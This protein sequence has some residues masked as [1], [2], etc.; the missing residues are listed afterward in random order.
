MIPHL[1]YRSFA[2]MN[3]VILHNLHKFPHNIDLIVGIPRSG[4][5]PAYLLALYLNK[6]VSD[7]DSFIEGRIQRGGDRKSIDKNTEIKKVLFLDDSFGLGAATNRLKKQLLIA[8]ILEKYE[9]FYAAIYTTKAGKSILD[10]YC[11]EVSTPR[12]FQWNIFHLGILESACCDIDGVL[13]PDPPIDDDGPE[14]INYITNAPSLYIPTV[15]IDT[16]VSCRLEKYRNIT[17]EWLHR[18]GVKYK[19]LIMLDLPDKA[20][21][22][23]WGKHGKYKAEVYKAENYNLFIE[24]SLQEALIIKKETGK[25]VFCVET[26]DMLNSTSMTEKGR[27][28]WEDVK[29]KPWHVLTFLPSIIMPQTYKKIKKIFKK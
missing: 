5:L 26:F 10:Y 8:G 11:E 3:S 13:C 12:A 29:R 21:R 7:V 20:T 24:S 27:Y 25:P 2:D 6:P 14:Y 22:V 4:M 1:E 23:A 9:V 19:N 18:H 16:L 15:E 17:E 28:Y